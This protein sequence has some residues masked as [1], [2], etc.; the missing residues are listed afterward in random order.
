MIHRFEA[1]RSPLRTA[2][3]MLVLPL[4][5]ANPVHGAV[6]DESA[7]AVDEALIPVSGP[8]GPDG[9]NDGAPDFTVSIGDVPA[10]LRTAGKRDVKWA[11][12]E[13][14]VLDPHWSDRGRTVLFKTRYRCTGS[15][16]AVDIRNWGA[17]GKFALPSPGS[18][19]VADSV[20]TQT[21]PTDWKWKPFYTPRQGS[22]T[23]VPG[24]AYFRGGAAGK[25]VAPPG[26]VQSLGHGRS[27]ITYV[28]GA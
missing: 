2:A 20:Q 27:N 24:W 22:G 4:L 17:L 13:A 26:I 21:Y 8:Y 1:I 3:A 18:S 28:E 7:V 6:A 15:Y 9:A 11:Y 10:T 12:C 25:I 5:I 14:E 16:Q 19:V 23:N